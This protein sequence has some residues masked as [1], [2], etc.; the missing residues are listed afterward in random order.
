MSCAHTQ[1]G[2]YFWQQQDSPTETWLKQF[3]RTGM[4][5][6]DNALVNTIMRYKIA[7]S[8][9]K[10]LLELFQSALANRPLAGGIELAALKKECRADW[11]RL[12]ERIEN[13]EAAYR[14]KNTELIQKD[15]ELSVEKLRH[16]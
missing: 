14:K 8:D 15:M 12:H 5:S 11:V 1:V 13:V 3:D 16:R 6:A 2:G 10:R 9:K 7:S 4:S